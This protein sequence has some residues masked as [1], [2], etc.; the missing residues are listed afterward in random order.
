MKSS[1]EEQRHAL[2]E[3]IDASRAVYRRMLADANASSAARRPIRQGRLK[4]QAHVVERT[5]QWMMDHPLYVAGGVALIAMLAPRII[6][7]G[8][9][10][11]D[12]T[13]EQASA[14]APQHLT[15]TRRALLAA[16][17]LLLRDP[18]RM[19]A[20]ARLLQS[21]WQWVRQQRA[22]TSSGAPSSM[23]KTVR[24]D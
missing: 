10:T 12:A 14:S 22:A 5:M 16:G 24:L 11:A 18:A 7:A 2:L 13:S 8:K 20:A 19:H 15:G 3:Q 23:T 17:A 21:T 4:H 6:G 9:R 1:L